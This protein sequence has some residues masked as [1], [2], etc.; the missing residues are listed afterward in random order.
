[1]G[2]STIYG[3][4]C[5]KPTPSTIN[6]AR[7]LQRA[8]G[9]ARVWLLIDETESTETW[10]HDIQRLALTPAYLAGFS[11]MPSISS[12]G[13]RCGDY[14]LYLAA[15]HLAFDHMWLI[16]SDVY[17]HSD[18]IAA[19]LEPAETDLDLAAFNL[20]P[21][22]ESWYWTSSMR[23]LGYSDI[24]RCLFPLV[25]ISRA[26]IQACAAARSE[27]HRTFDPAR[28]HY[29]NDESLVATEVVSRGFS[30]TPLERLLVG[31][32]SRFQYRN[33]YRLSELLPQLTSEQIVHSA[34]DDQEF[35][36]H[37]LAKV[38]ALLSG[39]SELTHFL[40][41]HIEYSRGEG[42]E[43]LRALVLTAVSQRIDELIASAPDMNGS[44]RP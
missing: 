4:R 19:L 13:W 21:A 2:S 20:G 28:G 29:P 27:M 5:H 31:K 3:V 15:D 17:F 42:R 11:G 32:M 41:H 26:A 40:S 24:Y 16:E 14:F 7:A 37:A 23:S 44:S 9:P 1:M 35:E 25:R 12:I 18:D 22:D 8:F 43:H 30:H 38:T 6:L 34:L 10:P 39:V 36:A 33:K